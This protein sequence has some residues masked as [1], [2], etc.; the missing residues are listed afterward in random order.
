MS[1]RVNNKLWVISDTHFGHQNIIKFQQRPV[2]HEVIMLSEWAERVDQRHQILHLG[3][4]FLGKGGNAKRWAS[5]IRYMPGEKFLV[6]GNHDKQKPELYEYAGF[7]IVK[8]FVYEGFAFTHYPITSRESKYFNVQADDY[9]HT[10]IH[11]HTHSN[12]YKPDHDGIPIEDKR[13]INVCVEHTN[14][15]PVQ[16][17]NIWS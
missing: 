17:G 14:L 1:L 5:I 16:L 10:N 9:W 6:M 4:V 13:Y 7:T 3:D 11:G 15:A 8:P 12:E 2:N